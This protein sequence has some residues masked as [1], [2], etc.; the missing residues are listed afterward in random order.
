M[1]TPEHEL[2]L[3]LCKFIR[4]DSEKIKRLMAYTL[5]WP[6]ILGQLLFHRMGSAAYHILRECG[7]LGRLNREVRNTLKTVYNSAV[8][9]SESIKCALAELAGLLEIAD[10]PF[11][12][13]KGA[14]LISLYPVGLRTSNDIDILISQAD[15]TRM[16]KLLKTYGFEQG[17]I[18]NGSF[19]PA[20]RAEILSSRM[21][22][23]EVVPFIMRMDLPEMKF[24]EI[25][26]NFSLDFKAKQENDLVFDLLK[27]TQPLIKTARGELFTL[28][29]ADFLIHL[30]CHLYKEAS[31]YA[32]VEMNRDLSLYKFTDIYLLLNKWGD[33]SFYSELQ[34]RIID[35]GL[36]KECY[37]ALLYTSELFEYD[38]SRF[39]QLLCAIR[40]QDTRYLQSIV[41]PEEKKVYQYQE[42]FTDWLF[43]H[44]RKEHLY[45]VTNEGT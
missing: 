44:N 18:R 7:L 45:E 28:T 27:K 42:G 12:L 14:Y 19:A 38:G 22:R 10:F 17:N 24:L 15:I 8:I 35:H 40:P 25:D 6:Y 26:I 4:P 29:P 34:E 13:L 39:N 16:E 41:H 32:W 23:G 36:Q 2:I 11:A 9:K 5:N 30:C 21:N 33:T 1:M 20:S 31:V 43:I 3:D 37:Y